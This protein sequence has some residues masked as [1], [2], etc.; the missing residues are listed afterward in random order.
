MSVNPSPN[1]G[2]PGQVIHGSSGN[3]PAVAGS[4]NHQRPEPIAEHDRIAPRVMPAASTLGSNKEYS[5]VVINFFDTL[6]VVAENGHP[7]KFVQTEYLSRTAEQ[8]EPLRSSSVQ[9]ANIAR[10]PADLFKVLD[11]ILS[12]PPRTTRDTY[13]DIIKVF[14]E[15]QEVMLALKTIYKPPATVEGDDVLI[16]PFMEWCKTAKESL[17]HLGSRCR[18]AVEALTIRNKARTELDRLSRMYDELTATLRNRESVNAQAQKVVWLRGILVEVL[19]Q[20]FKTYNQVQCD[21]ARLFLRRFNIVDQFVFEDIERR[22]TD[23]LGLWETYPT[24]QDMDVYALNVYKTISADLAPF[25]EKIRTFTPTAYEQNQMQVNCISPKMAKLK[26]DANTYITS[27]EATLGQGNSLIKQMDNLRVSINNLQLS[28]HYFD[29]SSMGL[30]QDEFEVL[31]AKCRDKVAAE[32]SKKSLRDHR[33]KIEAQELAKSSMGSANLLSINPL[34]GIDTWLSF[35]RS[36]QEVVALHESDQIRKAVTLKALVVKEDKAACLDLPYTEM[37]TWLR[38]KYDDPN[39]LV[40]IVEGLKRLP[41]ATSDKTSYHNLTQFATAMNQLKLHHSESKL[42]KSTRHD[43]LRILLVR[44]HLMQF[45]AEE[46]EFEKTL[47]GDDSDD[48][49]DAISVVSAGNDEDKEL[50]RREFYVQRMEHFLSI[51]RSMCTTITAHTSTKSTK[52]KGSSRTRGY[53]AIPSQPGNTSVSNHI[54]VLCKVQHKDGLGNTMLSLAKCPK[55]KKLSTQARF[56][57]VNKVKYCKR[58]LK[59]KT[60]SNHDNGCEESISRG[61]NCKNHDPP[62]TSHHVMLCLEKGKQ[63]KQ[64]KGPS[65]ST[66][67][68]SKKPYYKKSKSSNNSVSV[69]GATPPAMSCTNPNAAFQYQVTPVVPQPGT[70]V[71]QQPAPA[72]VQ[73]TTSHMANVTSPL[74]RTPTHPAPAPVFETFTPRL[75]NTTRAFLANPGAPVEHDC[76]LVRELMSCATYVTAIAN[77]Q[78]GEDVNLLCMQD[79]GSGLGFCTLDAAKRLNL[80]QNG[81]WHGSIQTLDGDHEGVYPVYGLLLKDIHG[82]VHW[83]KLLGVHHIGKKS[84]IPQQRFTTMCQSFGLDPGSCQNTQG[85]FDILLGVDSCSLLADRAPQFTSAMFPEAAVFHSILSPYY[86][87]VGAAGSPLDRDVRT[88]SYR[89]EQNIPNH[90]MPQRWHRQQAIAQTGSAFRV[91]YF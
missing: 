61:N 76:E 17:I 79:T 74:Q 55:F 62:S 8:L 36:H 14:T 39:M 15:S 53:A 47:K 60:Y 67:K 13:T 11:I 21:H 50:Q 3:M 22:L 5:D 90:F 78:F 82:Q 49:N 1:P 84:A 89:C 83:V 41:P 85:D 52:P 32:E 63:S 31:Y 86:F 18:M 26:I 12:G 88:C 2:S 20:Y 44:E 29:E 59:D 38:N 33:D 48:P 43:L 70:P 35:V 24:V 10:Y 30:T 68:K 37:M 65:D 56:D 54:C 19:D 40:R 81:S 75:L 91:R 72:P 71:S 6:K 28:G 27:D 87:I 42:D 16:M 9:L 64:G 7:K 34:K 23:S 66:P 69:Q 58:C 57:L 77:T 80:P 45:I 25:L 73:Q 46:R 51:I 4:P